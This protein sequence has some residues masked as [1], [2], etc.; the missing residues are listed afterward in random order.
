MVKNDDVEK[1]QQSLTNVTGGVNNLGANA[2]NAAHGSVLQSQLSM[3]SPV[4]NEVSNQRPHHRQYLNYNN[5]RLQL[6]LT[7]IHSDT[8]KFVN[9]QYGKAVKLP[10]DPWLRQQLDTVEHFVRQNVNLSCMDPP[11]KILSYK[12]IWRGNEIYVKQAPW[13][14]VLQEVAANSFEILDLATNFGPGHF[15]LSLELPYVFIGQHKNGENCSLSMSLV[16]AIFHREPTSS[17]PI[18]VPAAEKKG[19]IRK[20]K[21]NATSS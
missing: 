9:N 6:L 17:A 2:A 15:Q 3:T 11:P 13:C 10:V 14:N 20:E 7:N 19:R 8:V 1:D 4:L 18:T 21:K 16:Q 5:S 12:P